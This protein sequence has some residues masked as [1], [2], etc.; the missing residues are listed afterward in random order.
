MH[1]TQS[2]F[3]AFPSL[4]R[5]LRALPGFGRLDQG[6]VE[7]ALEGYSLEATEDSLEEFL[8]C[9]LN[10]DT[11]TYCFMSDYCEERSTMKEMHKVVDFARQNTTE[12]A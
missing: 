8:E 7:A 1:D 5:R 11:Q 2:P 9:L 6:V 3:N 10:Q 4:T 12:D